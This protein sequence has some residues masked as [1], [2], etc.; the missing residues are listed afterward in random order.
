MSTFCWIIS[1][2]KK[3]CL[4]DCYLPKMP[5]QEKSLT[6]EVFLYYEFPK[7]FRARVLP[8]KV[9]YEPI[10]LLITALNL[11]IYLFNLV[12]AVAIRMLFL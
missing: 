7:H 3:R 2:N 11:V 4:S 9:C 12:L 6:L 1:Y 10:F 8:S 5:E